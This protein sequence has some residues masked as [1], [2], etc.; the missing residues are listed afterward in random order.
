MAWNQTGRHMNTINEL[1][2]N[3]GI[4]ALAEET[5]DTSGITGVKYV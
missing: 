2:V 4:N 3:A 5:A 1:S